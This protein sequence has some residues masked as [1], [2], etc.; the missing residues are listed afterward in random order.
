MNGR[1]VIMKPY[2]DELPIIVNLEI[3][4]KYHSATQAKVAG[5]KKKG[6]PVTEYQQTL[7]IFTIHNKELNELHPAFDYVKYVTELGLK[8]R[9]IDGLLYLVH[10]NCIYE[11]NFYF[12]SVQV[13]DNTLGINKTLQVKNLP[14]LA[15]KSLEEL[16]DLC[17]LHETA[18]KVELIFKNKEKVDKLNGENIE[19]KP[20]L[21]YND[22]QFV[23][24]VLAFAI[25]SRFNT[26]KNT[27]N[28][29]LREAVIDIKYPS[30]HI[31]NDLIESFP[32]PPQNYQDARSDFR[33]HIIYTCLDYLKQ[34][35]NVD[36][37][38]SEIPKSV[39]L[40]IYSILS[41]FRLIDLSQILKH[42]DNAAR[43]KYLRSAAFNAGNL[44]NPRSKH[45][46]NRKY[47]SYDF[48]DIS[49]ESI[50]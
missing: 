35:A 44:N 6:L 8:E 13:I 17:R 9:T 39:A 25:Q 20:D 7:T 30:L 19:V 18:D 49:F 38:K 47:L 2:T 33:K 34:E 16:R 5:L 15:L 22:P 46:F 40:L 23:K 26:A 41:L 28:P 21:N 10:S 42:K 12:N 48:K 37:A 36:V 14:A 27:P 32:L 45:V 43:I 50:E 4:A 3:V 29:E 31:L 1:V 11:W 24:D